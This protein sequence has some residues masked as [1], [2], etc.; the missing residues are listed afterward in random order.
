MDDTPC[1]GAG[2]ASASCHRCLTVSQEILSM[3]A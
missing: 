1:T 2:A 3:I